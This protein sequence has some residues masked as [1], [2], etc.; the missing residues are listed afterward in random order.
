MS[1]GAGYTLLEMVVVLALLGLA[2]AMVAPATFRMIQSWRDADEVAQVLAEL[3]A[4]PAAAREQGR[5]LQLAS[6][7]A[8]AATGL[9]STRQPPD[10]VESAPIALPDGWH[11]EMDSPL[12]VRANGACGDATG[13][14]VTTRQQIRFRVE[15]PFCRI[16]RLPAGTP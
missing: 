3:A 12:L 11:L 1:R 6:P 2:T 5:E 14:L 4:L 8:P 7:P 15:A 13:T 10:P 9:A 16:E